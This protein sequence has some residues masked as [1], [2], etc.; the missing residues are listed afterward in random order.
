MPSLPVMQSFLPR[1][2]FGNVSRVARYGSAVAVTTLATVL[3][4]LMWAWLGPTISPLFFI[5]VLFVAWYGGLRPGL[6][7]ATLSAAAC[8]LVFRSFLVAP[9]SP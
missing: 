4:Y 1:V 3:S 9:T 2:P 7:C 5:G 6:L 8:T